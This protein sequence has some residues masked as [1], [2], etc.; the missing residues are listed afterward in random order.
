MTSP[1]SV[2]HPTLGV[3]L[4]QRA[5]SASD[6]RLAL[7]AGLGIVCALAIVLLRPAYWIVWA[8][9]ALCFV[10]F[11]AWGIADRSL[12]GAAGQPALERVLRV[13]RALAVGLGALSAT[14]FGLGVMMIAVGTWIS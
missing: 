1:R 5:R 2:G 8:S 4:A 12:A 11:G 6:L 14:L 3:L 13:S 7:D 9:A 10:A